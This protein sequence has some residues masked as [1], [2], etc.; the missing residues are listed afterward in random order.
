MICPGCGRPGSFVGVKDGYK[1]ERC[2]CGTLYVPDRSPDY[3]YVGGSGCVYDYVAPDVSMK[4]LTTLVQDLERFRQTS[5]WLDMGFG[6][7]EL[8]AICQENGWDSYGTE[9]A[10]KSL[11]IGRAKGWHVSESAA[12]FSKDFDVVTMNGFIE[13]LPDPGSLIAE[14][15][16]LLRRGGVLWISTPNARS[17]NGRVL[18]LEWNA[19][20]PPQHLIIWSA[21]GI[22]LAL[23]RFGFRVIRVETTG[24]SPY[25]IIARFTRKQRSGADHDTMDA[26][27]NAAASRFRAKTLIN[28]AL[29]L[30]QMGDTLKIL[31]MTPP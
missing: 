14:A 15:K 3:D 31:A 29:S 8:L 16:A 19:V 25:G 26:R 17:L 18:G 6:R 11:E 27:L 21:E 30:V 23:E 28:R 1:F 13:H 9:L 22:R 4:S 5:R 24:I 10:Q 7:G 2:L 12:N 20:E